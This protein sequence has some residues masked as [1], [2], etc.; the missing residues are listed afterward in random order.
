[1]DVETQ[2]P[3]IART[4]AAAAEAFAAEARSAAGGELGAAAVRRVNAEMYQRLELAEL[5]HEAETTP[6]RIQR[7]I[8]SE[9]VV[10]TCAEHR[11]RFEPLGTV[12]IRGLMEPMQLCRLRPLAVGDGS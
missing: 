11:A 12:T 8:Q 9:P 6:E 2:A 3:E 5:A 7:L 10:E 4:T 1:V